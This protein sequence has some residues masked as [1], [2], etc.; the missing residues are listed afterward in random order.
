V[1]DSQHTSFDVAIVGGGV[2]GL[3]V[4][5]RARARGLTVCLLDRGPLGDGATHAAAGMLAPVTEA[6]PGER[7]LLTLGL[8]SARRWPAF[9]DELRDVTAIDVGYRAT[10]TLVVARDRDELEALDRELALRERL[11]LEAHRLMPS[12]ARGLE[13]ALAPTV[14]GGLHVPSD[15]SADPR[16]LVAALI[17]AC[18]GAG[19]VLRPGCEATRLIADAGRATGVELRGG[20]VVRAAS[21][22]VAAGAWSADLEGVPADARV[23]VR[24]VKGQ[25]MRLRDRSGPG[26]LDRVLRYEGGYVVPRG[27][28]S[29]VLGATQEERG[30]DTRLTALGVYE[31]LR[32]AQ[33]LIPGLLELEIAEAQAGLRPGTPDNAPALGASGALDGLFWATGHHRNGILLAP[34]TGD[35]LATELSGEGAVAEAFS[36]DRFAEVRA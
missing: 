13:P 12:Q 10:G 19:A 20:D 31:M 11:G 23:P 35:L 16:A 25:I 29:Y 7:A 9:A 18:E 5:W 14:R 30:F 17:A 36:P 15:H 2:C 3:V 24:P 27:D 6:D 33:E 8:E 4:A 34:M 32:D 22:V 26:L 28:G 21:V 1:V